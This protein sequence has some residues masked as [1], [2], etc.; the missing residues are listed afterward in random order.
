MNLAD[1]LVSPSEYDGTTL[2]LPWEAVIGNGYEVL[3]VSVFGN[4][5]LVDPSGK[6]WLLDSWTGEL[7]GVSLSYAEYK[8]ELNSNPDFFT[9]WFL[10]PLIAQM[11]SQ[12]LV[13]RSGYVFAPFISP[14]LG[15][16][17]SPKN[18]SLAPLA[19]YVALSAHEI[20]AI[21]GL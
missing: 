19:A 7:H 3:H 4:F 17:L 16:S 11:T 6:I 12:G 5:F 20:R 14:G 1:A 21:K 10:L 13:R 15:G 9:S 18:F 2:I 8:N